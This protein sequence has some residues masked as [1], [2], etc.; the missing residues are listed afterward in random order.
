MYEW[1]RTSDTNFKYQWQRD[2]LWYS[3]WGGSGI[4][5]LLHH[6]QPKWLL[7]NSRLI[8]GF[9]AGSR[10]PELLSLYFA[11]DKLSNWHP[12]FCSVRDP[13]GGRPHLL[14]VQDM[15]DLENIPAFSAKNWWEEVTG[16]KV[17]HLA[18][19]VR[20]GT[21]EDAYGPDELIEELTDL[22]EQA[23]AAGDKGMRSASGEK[24]LPSLTRDA[25]CMVGSA[26]FTW[27]D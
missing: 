14:S 6:G 3:T 17:V 20:S 8:P 10:I 23:V 13:S 22:S 12:Q 15:L 18:Q 1:P 27:S 7:R 26:S 4:Q 19:Y 11:G 5:E 25:F 16:D 2:L 21:P 9:Q 24:E